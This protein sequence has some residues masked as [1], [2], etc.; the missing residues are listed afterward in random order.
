MILIQKT[1]VICGT[2]FGVPAHREHT[3][4]TCSRQCR[5][6]SNAKKYAAKR[7]GVVC[8][9]CGHTFFVPPSHGKRRMYCSAA[10]AAPSRASNRPKGDRHYHWGGGRTYHQEG[11][12]YVVMKDHPFA[13]HSGGYVFEHRVIMETWMRNQV[14]NHP[15][16]VDVGGV[17]YLRS[18]IEIHHINGVKRDNRPANLLACTPPAHRAIHSGVAPMSGEVWP[19]IEGLTPFRPRVVERSCKTCGAIFFAK[20]CDVD[21]GGGKFC[22]ALC[23]KNRDR[24][25]FKVT[26]LS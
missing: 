2:V 18:R 24:S 23:F 15:F 26:V 5:S 25:G 4:T 16:L 1:C 3:A 14:P 21:R 6:V 17:S 13:S 11:Y 12:L 22:S 19:E 9:G 20:R 10:C 8:K 7:T